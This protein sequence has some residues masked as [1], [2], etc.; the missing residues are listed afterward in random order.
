MS[1][2]SLP[3]LPQRRVSETAF[4]QF[5]INLS[6]LL[7]A[8]MPVHAALR[9]LIRVGGPRNIIAL[10]NEFDEAIQS[11]QSLSAAMSD[12]PTVVSGVA[13]SLVESAER[14][15]AL[16]SAFE[17]I[18]KLINQKLENKARLHNALVYPI[19]LAVVVGLT[20]VFLLAVLVPSVK[21]LM[22]STGVT[23]GS[24]SLFMFWLAEKGAVIVPILAV[25]SLVLIL[26]FV[27]YLL[28]S[29]IRQLW[30]GCL[31]RIW[32]IGPI[33]RDLHYAR[34][35]QICSRLFASGLDVDTTLEI[36][37]RSVGNKLIEHDLHCIR[38]R[39][40]VGNSFYQ[41]M[42]GLPTL[43][44]SLAPLVGAAEAS[45]EMATA[46]Y[47]AGEQLERQANDRLIRFTT[48]VPPIL[49]SGMGLLLLS[50]VVGLLGPLLGS[51]I[52]MGAG[53]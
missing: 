36:A 18:A 16:G 35:C 5:S 49:I 17:D 52:S 15:G 47:H 33:R 8:G 2:S 46:L 28:N 50:L 48:V 32:M 44:Q 10:I 7:K 30:H 9:H 24:V 22:L 39:L 37:S 45:G 12:H 41:S 38:Q 34:L 1:N 6:Y 3:V 43:P 14:D 51:A 26:F 27:L 31:L 40:S 25:V 21:P 4:A 20:L 29:Q 13:I 53:L 11:G 23:P 19:V 42:A